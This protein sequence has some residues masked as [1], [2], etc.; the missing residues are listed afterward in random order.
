MVR[1]GELA[2]EKR[3][4]GDAIGC[5]RIQAG[6]EDAKVVD[7]EDWIHDN[8]NRLRRGLQDGEGEW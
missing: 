1:E 7:D 6:T 5:K 8:R 3:V 4:I 2:R